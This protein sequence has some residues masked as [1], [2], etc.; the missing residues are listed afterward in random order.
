[1]S[2]GD[3]DVAPSRGVV[4]GDPSPYSCAAHLY[5]EAGWPGPIPLRR[6]RKFP[7]P[8]GLTGSN[9]RYPT[10]DEIG[11]WSEGR[12]H[13]LPFDPYN[14][15]IRVQPGIVGIDV[16]HYGDKRGGDTLAD[17]TAALGTLAPTWV[18]TA[19][20]TPSG[21]RWFR[22]ADD[23]VLEG[24]L[25]SGI[26]TVQHHHRYAMVW[27]SIH[28]D[29]AVGSYVWVTPDGELADGPPSPE[30]LPYLS[31]G[32]VERFRVDRVLVDRVDGP[33][34]G[35]HREDVWHPKVK[36]ALDDAVIR[37]G[38]GVSRHDTMVA[39]VQRLARYEER[40][41]PGATTAIDVL[42][43]SFLDAVAD[44]PH[45]PAR[46]EWEKARKSGRDNVRTS[47]STSSAY[48]DGGLAAQILYE[49]AEV[50]AASAAREVAPDESAV[51]SGP[52]PIDWS[53]FWNRDRG[54]EEWAIPGILPARRAA[55]IYAAHKTG[56]SLLSLDLAVSVATGRP[57]LGQDATEP[58]DVVYLDMEMTEDD[59]DERLTDLGVGPGDDVSRL[60]YYLLPTIPPLDTASGGL[61]LREIVRR[62]GATLV[63]IDTM[64]RAV[65]G[66]E[67]SADTYRAYYLHTWL[68]LKQDGAAVLRLDHAGKDVTKRERGSSAKGDDV[69]LS[70]ELRSTGGSDFL[71]TRKFSRVSWVP[72]KIPLRRET[73]PLRHVIAAQSFPP[74]T[75]Q[76]VSHLDALGVPI[77]A[78]VSVALAALQAAKLSPRG[79]P[80]VVAAQRT[81]RGPRPVDLDLLSGS[82]T[83]PADRA[84]NR[85]V[86]PEG[87]G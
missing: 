85:G 71:L 59:L 79:K 38:S 32:W 31:P 53:E 62:H 43:E 11:G 12:Q 2:T 14:I 84:A 45:R 58:R 39:A 60:H 72:E 17:L 76:C 52:Q 83:A 29:P 27:P 77:D 1:M 4:E 63:V 6:G 15:A 5:A 44:E 20:P 57:V 66:E 54:S 80:I 30:D 78:P 28:P 67:N 46:N 49:M 74:G 21:I 61:L 8:T 64:A 26:E 40:G 82:R 87:A 56:K 33:A 47:P 35:E 70:W 25:G 86:E 7:P 19:R 3:L 48:D 50:R 10:P 69:D 65:A 42:G 13:W 55:T 22:V 37:L 68:L 36:R 73:E 51:P 75:A 24:V 81:R 23:V 9:G 41:Y 16:D 34:A 18:S